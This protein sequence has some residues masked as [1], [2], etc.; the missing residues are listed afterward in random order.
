MTP[1]LTIT[2]N[3]ALDLSASVPEVIA[4]PKLRCRAV[5]SDPGGGGINVSRVVSRLGGE[6]CALVALGGPTGTALAEALA[7]EG[8][9][10]H[11]VDVPGQTRQNIAI[12][13][14]KSGAQFRFVLPGEPW[15]DPVVDRLLANLMAQARPNDLVVLSGSQP[16]GAAQ[17]MGPR[18]A[19]ALHPVGAHLVVDTSGAPLRAVLDAAGRAP[20]PAILRMDAAE[21]DDLAGRALRSVSATASFAT[22][23]IRQGAAATVICARG[24]EGSVLADATGAWHAV[25]PSVPEVSKVGAGDSFV[26]GFTLALAR[27]ESP[28]EALRWG[29]AAAAATVTTEATRLCEASDVARLL[30]HCTVTPLSMA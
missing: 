8:V 13:E 19:T 24:A 11:A 17:D 14:E 5:T 10:M 28:Q 4:G 30:P 23:L 27:G 6:T 1:V 25:P 29:V 9:P 18:L 20:M 26:G 16:P 21:A 22:D 12:T 7:A 3:P 2:T 15:T